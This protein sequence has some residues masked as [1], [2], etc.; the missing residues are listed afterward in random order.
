MDP[1]DKKMK[2]YSSFQWVGSV[3][4]HFF[5]GFLSP[6]K[7]EKPFLST[8]TLVTTIFITSSFYT[9]TLAAT[10]HHHLHHFFLSLFLSNLFIGRDIS[11]FHNQQLVT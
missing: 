11:N 4:I 2:I 6:Q 7:E 3:T 10:V 1:T 9:Q 8:L 5:F